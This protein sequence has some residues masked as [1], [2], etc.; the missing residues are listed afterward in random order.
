L[1]G[2]LGRVETELLKQESQINS[3]ILGRSDAATGRRIKQARLSQRKFGRHQRTQL[4][5]TLTVTLFRISDQRFTPA[6]S[7]SWRAN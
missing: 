4:S 6:P 2:S 3:D 5:H 7:Q 1:P